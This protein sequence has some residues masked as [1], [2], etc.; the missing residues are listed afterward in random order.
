MRYKGDAKITRLRAYLE[1]RRVKIHRVATPDP[2]PGSRVRKLN[3]WRTEKLDLAS[4][5]SISG[6]YGVTVR[7]LKNGKA[8][9]QV[10]LYRG[11]FGGA[12]NGFGLNAHPIV[13][14]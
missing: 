8:R 4:T 6:I 9:S 13:R 7:Y 11:C 5:G 14:L 3:E 12:R 2:T 10:H 1:G